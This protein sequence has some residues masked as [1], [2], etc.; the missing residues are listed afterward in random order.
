MKGLI[1]IVCFVLAAFARAEG[2]V[3]YVLN[4]SF[5]EHTQCPD[6]WDQIKYAK[7]WSPIDT[8]AV[9]PFCSA[10][11]CNTC[12]SSYF[13]SIPSNGSF[14]QWPRTGNGMI[15][16]MMYYYMSEPSRDYSQ[17]RLRSTLIAG[18]SYCVT[19]FVNLEEISEY[20]VNHIG[21]YLDDGSIDI[22]QDSVGCS[23]V[24]NAFTPQVYTN[25]VI[26]DTQN[27]VKIEGSFIANGSEKFI[28]LGNFFTNAQTTLINTYYA[29][30]GGSVYLI[31]DVCLIESDLPAFAGHDTTITIGDSV[32][33][34]RTDLMPDVKWYVLGSNTI[35]D[36]SAGMWVKPDTTTS[37]VVAQT[38]CGLTTYDTVTVF[39]Y[40]VG[41][42]N[43]GYD[44]GFI[45]YPNP[46]S[47]DFE[48]KNLTG[49]KDMRLVISD[50]SGKE[51]YEQAI[52]AT[53]NKVHTKLPAGMYMVQMGNGRLRYLQKMVVE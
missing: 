30:N 10:D 36:S 50:M 8:T 48:V 4:P 44:K 32:F 25:T 11:Y 7:Y 26:T 22:G 21:A 46:S 28:T 16:H 45:V 27:W 31:D 1:L 51:V 17:G 41:V 39:A 14:Y 2:Q 53:N 23:A 29:N 24:Q 35:I 13:T 33:L 37:Y 34:G 43:V 5:E 18:K 20:A 3:N 47:G 9:D 12:S 42:N 49:E 15:Q 6:Q 52:I 40:P 38:L 19:F